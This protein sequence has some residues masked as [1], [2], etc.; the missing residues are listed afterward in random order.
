MQQNFKIIMGRVARNDLL[1]TTIDD[2]TKEGIN[3]RNTVEPDDK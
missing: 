1:I 2:I 3:F